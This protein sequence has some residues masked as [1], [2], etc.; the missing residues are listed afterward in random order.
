MAD[1]NAQLELKAPKLKGYLWIGGI[2]MTLLMAFYAVAIYNFT[3]D[4]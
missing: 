2:L 4:G 1:A 3:Q